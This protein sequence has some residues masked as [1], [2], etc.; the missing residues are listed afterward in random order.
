MYFVYKHL[1]MKLFWS[2]YCLIWIDFTH[3]SGVSIAEFEQLNVDWDSCRSTCYTLLVTPVIKTFKIITRYSKDP[4]WRETLWVLIETNNQNYYYPL[5]SIIYKI[6]ISSHYL[7]KLIISC[8]LF[9]KSY[10]HLQKPRT[11]EEKL[12]WF[13]VS[14]ELI[15]P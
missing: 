2:L 13:C 10:F 3:C 1:S 8:K 7:I 14:L 5:Y 15:P 6:N 11:L 9:T 12:A 4:V